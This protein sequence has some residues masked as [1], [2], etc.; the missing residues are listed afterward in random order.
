MR[1]EGKGSRRRRP[2]A[3][4]ALALL[5][6]YMAAGYL[7]TALRRVE[8]E[9]P[10]VPTTTLPALEGILLTG[11]FSVHTDR[12]HD[13]RGTR[14]QV[15]AA[16]ARGGLDFVVVGDHPPSPRKPGWEFW[17]PVFLQGVLVE[18][19]Q[20]LRAPEAGKLLV[21]GVDTTYRHWEESYDSMV[22]MLARRGATSLVVHGRGP[23]RSERWVHPTVTGV[24]GWEVLDVS[25]FARHRLRS[26]W[27]PYHLITAL[28]GFPLGMGDKAL[29]HLMREGFDTPTVAAYDS[30]RMG[31]PLVATA[32]L[33]VHPKLAVG[34][35]LLPPYRPFFTTMVCHLAAPGPLSPDPDEASAGLAEL[36]REGDLFIALGRHER[37]RAFRLGAV[38][39]TEV[40]ARM[41]RDTLA[42][43]GVVLRAGFEGEAPPRL[44]YRILRNGSE[45]AWLRGADLEWAPPGEGFYRVEVYTYGARLGNTFF[46]L[47]PWI[48]ANPMG[49]V[50]AGDGTE[51]TDGLV[52][53]GDGTE[54]TDGLVGAGDWT[55]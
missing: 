14:E 44:V 55:R 19:G 36:V 20:E 16:G 42:P 53:A 6:L 2:L 15:A 1:A 32:G 30:L 35:F 48:F 5:A 41:G 49:L 46:R 33:N 4:G 38:L 9:V 47:R 8:T 11:V 45:V 29:L 10:P 17:D 54:E 37:A 7:T 13:A 52:E 18:G 50:G 39:G 12:S 27:G 3:R 51:E 25:E 40:V 26:P 31:Q 22:S 24:Q 43:E 28:V 34:P 23:R 21:M